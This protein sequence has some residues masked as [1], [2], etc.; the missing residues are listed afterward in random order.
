MAYRA[1]AAIVYGLRMDSFEEAE[2]L[3]VCLN[4]KTGNR[5]REHIVAGSD[6]QPIFFAGVLLQETGECEASTFDPLLLFP[7]V[8]RDDRVALLKAVEG[9]E[10]EFHLVT[11]YF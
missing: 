11:M 4:I 2:A 3:Q 1:T 6:S 7:Q 9:R 8:S 10:P 5:G